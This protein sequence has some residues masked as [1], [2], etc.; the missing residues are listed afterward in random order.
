M[1][2]FTRIHGEIRDKFIIKNKISGLVVT[3][4][5]HKD[6]Y[7]CFTRYPA[8]FDSESDARR[9]LIEYGLTESDMDYICIENTNISYFNNGG[10]LVTF[11]D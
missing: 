6:G 11:E 1:M 10:V 9:Y 3:E 4:F 8:V 7:L 5:E 2:K